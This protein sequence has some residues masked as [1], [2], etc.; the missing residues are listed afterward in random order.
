MGAKDVL[1]V[2][3]LVVVGLLAYHFLVAGEGPAAT[4]GDGVGASS[5]YDPGEGEAG[6][7]LGGRG[8]ERR[9]AALE[10]KLAELA[11]RPGG[12]GAAARDPEAPPPVTAGTEWTDEDLASLRAGFQKMQEQNRR[13]AELTRYRM[14]V[15][16]LLPK[17]DEERREE[18]VQRL[19]R[20]T[21]DLKGLYPAPTPQGMTAEQREELQRQVGDLRA[22]LET[23]L[24][25]MVS[26]PE[27]KQI[28]RSMPGG[29]V[30]GIRQ[31]PVRPQPGAGGTSGSGIVGGAR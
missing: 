13:H 16:N 11:R 5:A 21:T 17:Q 19:T 3:V 2:I 8:L 31:P 10:R 28:M 18:V 30:P 1:L 24:K 23:D 29:R 14:L 6:P 9:L 4:A 12:P 27:A 15:K 25:S 26:D 7:G 20:Y 22:Q